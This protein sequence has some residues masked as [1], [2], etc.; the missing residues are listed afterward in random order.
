[1]SLRGIVSWTNPRA[2]CSHIFTDEIG[3]H[4][5]HSQKLNSQKPKPNFFTM[6]EIKALFLFCDTRR[7]SWQMSIK[8]H[9]GKL[10][11]IK[12]QETA[13]SFSTFVFVLWDFRWA[14]FFTICTICFAA[15]HHFL[16]CVAFWD[17]RLE[18]RERH[19]CKSSRFSIPIFQ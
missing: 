8:L 13:N 3:N 2:E 6:Q 10:L 5:V 15:L 12:L 4:L 14:F 18:V 16:L 1:M 11:L 9:F 7:V 19:A 17:N